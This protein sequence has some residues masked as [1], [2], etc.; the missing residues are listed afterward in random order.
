MRWIP[1]HLRAPVEISGW[2][3]CVPERVIT[4]EDLARE[5]GWT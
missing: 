5:T 2:G 3:M 4:N 1:E